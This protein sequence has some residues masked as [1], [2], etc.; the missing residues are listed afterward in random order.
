MK[1]LLFV[2]LATLALSAC[3]DSVGSV[4]WCNQLK[5]KPKSEWTTDNAVN[6]AKYCVFQ[7]EVGSKSWCKDMSNKPKGDWTGNEA[8]DYAKYCV[9]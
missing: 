4:N 8:V 6:F 7:N 1:K 5:E 9:F 3:T 2:I